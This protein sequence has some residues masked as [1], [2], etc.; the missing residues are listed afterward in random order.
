MTIFDTIAEPLRLHRLVKTK[1]ETVDEVARLMETCGL[2]PAYMRRYPHEFSGGQRQRVGIARALALKPRLVIADEPVSA[3][4]VSIRAQIV[5]LL[6]SLQ[7]QFGLAYVFVAHDLAVVRHL[8]REI[9]VMYL[10]RIVERAP[11]AELFARPAHPYTQALLSAIPIPD[12]V[13]ERRRK[14]LPLVGE[15]P[16]PLDP[17]AGCAF[18][19]RCP[20]AFD[21]CRVE[22]PPLLAREGD[23]QVACW[24]DKPPD[25]AEVSPDSVHV[26]AALP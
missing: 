18:H 24:L 20:Y 2:L 11:S 13:L 1:S 26:G 7:E 10:G 23:H 21:R 5:N 9:A 25:V 8:S 3:L 14:R 4:D 17:P 6:A 22:S 19:P 12:P 16:S 15:V